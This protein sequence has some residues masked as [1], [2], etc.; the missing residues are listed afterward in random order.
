MRAHSNFAE[1]VPISLLLIYLVEQ[2]GAGPL[3]V[4]ALG[5]CV[6]A[7]RLSHA[8]GVSRVNERYGY[9]VFGMSLT[10]TP[11]IVTSI[12]LLQVY[13]ARFGA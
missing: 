10:L 2:S 1:Y 7:G 12:R 5:L 8:V 13:A 4:H 3:F 6:L 9:R 11:L